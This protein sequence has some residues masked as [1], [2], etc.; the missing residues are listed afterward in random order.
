MKFNLVLAVLVLCSIV[1]L[2]SCK[3]KGRESM[4]SDLYYFPEKNI[5][6]DIK[7]ANYYYSLDSARSW[8]SMTYTGT[9]FGTALGTKI[10]LKRQGKNPWSN[11][12]SL[13]KVYHG[14]L[15]NLLNHRTFLIARTDSLRRLKP[16]VVIVKPK[17]AETSDTVKTKEEPP[18]KGIKK[19]F[20]KL[21][22]KKKDKKE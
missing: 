17:P 4:E 12:D 21:F 3:R 11:N 5:Y 15:L 10:A 8:D 7:T 20:N 2:F 1:T 6:Y 19:F 9:D 14:R 22:G 16:V 13:R 18:K